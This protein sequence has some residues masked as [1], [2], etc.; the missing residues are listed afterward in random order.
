MAIN[1]QKRDQKAHSVRREKE[2]AKLKR[3]LAQKAAEAKDP[4][5]KVARLAANVPRTVDNTKQWLGDNGEG[6]ARLRPVQ[7]AEGGGEGGEDLTLDMAGLEKLF[8]PAATTSTAAHPVTLLTTCPKPSADNVAFLNELQSFFGGPSAAVV[9]PRYSA[10]FELSKVTKWAAKR[11]YGAVI[12]VGEDNKGG[13][14]RFLLFFLSERACLILK[15]ATFLLYSA[16]SM[17]VT[18][19]PNGPSA[20]FRLTSVVSSKSIPVNHDLQTFRC[21]DRR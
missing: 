15:T 11:G 13:P 20:H 7:L 21:E 12:I 10:R 3:R 8:P 14:G 2:Q 4:S 9:L 17:T 16:A 19:L 6:D 1:A 18:N 5:L